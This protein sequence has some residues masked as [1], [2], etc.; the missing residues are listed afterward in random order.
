VSGPPHTLHNNPN[1]IVHLGLGAELLLCNAKQ[2]PEG[3]NCWVWGNGQN[4]FIYFC[5]LDFFVVDCSN[6]VDFMEGNGAI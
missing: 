5:L 4:L 3:L 6:F 2:Q 1:T